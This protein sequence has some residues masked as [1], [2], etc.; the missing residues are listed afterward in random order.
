MVDFHFIFIALFYLVVILFIHIQLKK[1]MPQKEIITST[2]SILSSKPLQ[3]KIINENLVEPLNM[4]ELEEYDN[5][6]SIIDN[7]GYDLT[8]EWSKVYE[9]S[10]MNVKEETVQ[11]NMSTLDPE[12]QKTSLLDEGTNINSDNMNINPFDEFETTSYLSFAPTN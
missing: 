2:K 6:K 8:D 10:K 9:T 5:F 11:N 7:D 1:S 3:N 4:D 12:Y